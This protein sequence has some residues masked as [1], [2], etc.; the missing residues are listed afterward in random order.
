MSEPGTGPA[1]PPQESPV[2]EP[3]GAAPVDQ[4]VD[5]N[6]AVRTAG[7]VAG[8]GPTVPLAAAAQA[9]ADLRD[10]AARA[11]AHV[12]RVTGLSAPTTSGVLVVDRAGWARANADVFRT[13]LEPVVAE[14]FS[15][16]PGGQ[17]QPAAVVAVGSR[18]AGAEVGALLGFL[19]SRVLGQYDPFAEP[20]RLLLVAPNVVT[21]ETELDVPPADFRLW[22][23]LHEETHRVQFDANPWLAPHLLGRIRSLSGGMLGVGTEASFRHLRVW[24]ALPNA[25]WE[26]NKAKLSTG[27]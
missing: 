7:A 14:S 24:E 4:L 8:K 18:V 12:T 3:T 23:C 1:T 5:W 19:A 20:G 26:K 17:S 27:R 22:V 13:L 11:G 25:A 10:A 9:V 15:R 6:L 21:A 16:R 2:D